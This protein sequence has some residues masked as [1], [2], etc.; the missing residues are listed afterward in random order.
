MASRVIVIDNKHS[1]SKVMEWLERNIGPVT[2]SGLIAEGLDTMPEGSH[3]KLINKPTRYRS[4]VRFA[5][6]FDNTVEESI[7]LYFTLRWA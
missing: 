3:W 7:I 5:A 4:N 2:N 6:E 1:I